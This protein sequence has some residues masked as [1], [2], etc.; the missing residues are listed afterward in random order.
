MAAPAHSS[1]PNSQGTAAL[2]GRRILLVDD[3][4]VLLRV[5]SRTLTQH[6]LVV[7]AA[8]GVEQARQ[9]LLGWRRR[10]FQYALVD[11]RLSD[12]FGLDLVPALSELRPAPGFAVVSAYPST[13]RALRAWQRELVIVPKPSSPSG[14]LEL[15]GF[16]ETRRSKARKRNYK[17]GTR[18]LEAVQFGA[19]VLDADGL[20]GPGF[21]LQLSAVLQEVLARL[22]GYGGDWVA[23]IQLARDIY[24]REDAHSMMLLRRQISLLRRALGEQRWIIESQLQRGYRI[25]PG[26]LCV[27]PEPIAT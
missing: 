18:M 20:N 4:P 23:T 14:L 27:E 13:E 17:H 3:D 10:P 5:W 1:E 11:D 22:V 8:S 24:A 12:G 26:A 15:I 6:G 25:A 19:Y 7:R 9:L 21:Q 16:L 2:R